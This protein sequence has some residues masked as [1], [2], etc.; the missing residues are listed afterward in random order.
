MTAGPR[1]IFGYGSLVWRPDFPFEE[2]RPAWV[3]GW[4]RRFWQ[5]SPDHR[6]TPESPGR[7]ATMLRWP[8]TRCW[9]MA[10]RVAESDVSAVLERLDDREVAGYQRQDVSLC[11]AD[12]DEP[13]AVGVTWVATASNP[14]F[15]GIASPERMVDQIRVAAGASGSNLEYVLRLAEALRALGVDEDEDQ[16]EVFELEA[17]LRG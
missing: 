9:G 11:G 17:L 14:N 8:G 10:Y 2:R 3:D 12:G 7:V 1:W 13:F 16:D 4:R 6:G 15:V 5:S